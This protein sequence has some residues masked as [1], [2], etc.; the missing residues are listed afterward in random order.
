MDTSAL[1]AFV[2]AG[3]L[4]GVVYSYYNKLFTVATYLEAL[5]HAG[6]GVAVGALVFFGALGSGWAVPS[7]WATALPVAALGYAGTDVI[8]T[9]AQSLAAKTTTPKTP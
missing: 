1:V 2:V 4:G 5:Y 6:A 3:G 7:D 9:L 8:D